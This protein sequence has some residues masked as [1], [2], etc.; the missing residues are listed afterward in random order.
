MLQPLKILVHGRG[1][2]ESHWDDAAIIEKR[3]PSWGDMEPLNIF[4]SYSHKV[5]K[6]AAGLKAGLEDFGFSAFLAH[7][8]IRPS[9]RWR[10]EIR[11]ALRECDI[12]MPLL[13]GA[14]SDSDWTDQETGFALALRKTMIPV[15]LHR[16]QNPHGFIDHI[17]ALKW[18]K[19]SSYAS[20]WD[21]AACIGGNEKFRDVARDGAIQAFSVAS[22]F[23]TEV[24]IAARALLRFRPFSAKQ[25][26]RIIDKSSRRHAI[27][28]CFAAQH[29][30]REL[31]EDA[32]GKVSNRVIRRYRESVRSW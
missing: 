11:K 19:E 5:K 23:K 7:E 1:A 10:N 26:H 20:A 8:D 12:F 27:Y 25:M 18:N 17:Q 22:D 6:L 13:S 29:S 3:H 24:P 15:K 2:Q 4:L 14:F 31:I 16:D 21:V 28:G 32:E 30:M 9:A